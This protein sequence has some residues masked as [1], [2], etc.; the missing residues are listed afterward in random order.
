MHRICLPPR[1]FLPVT[2]I[3]QQASA[4]G[5]LGP[6]RSRGRGQGAVNRDPSQPFNTPPIRIFSTAAWKTHEA[7]TTTRSSWPTGASC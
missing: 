4:C 2:M 5:T 1:P 6:A 3:A 7:S